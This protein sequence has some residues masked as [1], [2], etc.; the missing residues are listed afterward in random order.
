MGIQ[1]FLCI[2]GNSEIFEILICRDHVGILFILA[3]IPAGDGDRFITN[4]VIHLG[5]LLLGIT[6]LVSD[7]TEVVTYV[8]FIHCLLPLWFFGRLRIYC[9]RHVGPVKRVLG[10]KHYNG[11]EKTMRTAFNSERLRVLR[12]RRSLSQEEVAHALGSSRGN[13]GKKEKGIVKTSADDLVK[14]AAFYGITVPQIFED[15]QTD[16]DEAKMKK[17]IEDL[18]RIVTKL[19]AEIDELKEKN[20]LL[21]EELDKQANP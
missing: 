18:T 14:L 8:D 11:R 12:E 5:H 15:P 3:D 19:H 10:H 1:L 21:R 2:R 4:T 7:P 20:Q 13:Y 6:Q 17:L 16:E 9:A